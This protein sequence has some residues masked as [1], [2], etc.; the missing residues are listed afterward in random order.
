M[1]LVTVGGDTHS[2]LRLLN[3]VE[4]LVK[5]HKINDNVI[6]QT[7]Y[8]K[9]QSESRQC[10]DFVIMDKFEELVERCTLIISHAGAGTIMMGLKYRKPVIIMPRLKK[11]NE[12]IN[13][14]QLQLTRTLAEKK[15][16]I[17]AY[18]VS[19]LEKAIEMAAAFKPDS[20][21]T[22]TNEIIRSIERYCEINS[23]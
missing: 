18:N 8:T 7:G 14:H 20:F 11:F 2:F 6:F 4:K 1:I 10:C 5:C 16:I 12:H 3:G 19:N 22:G 21:N 9:F 23:F 15:K 13:N 17:P